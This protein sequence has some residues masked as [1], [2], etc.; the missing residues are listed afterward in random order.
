MKKHRTRV[1][2]CLTANQLAIVDTARQGERSHTGTMPMRSAMIGKL[3]EQAVQGVS[4]PTRVRTYAELLATV[5]NHERRI[6]A[7][8]TNLDDSGLT[9]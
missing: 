9:R 3:I 5:D 7:I 1:E 2:V 6:E 4:I 8:E